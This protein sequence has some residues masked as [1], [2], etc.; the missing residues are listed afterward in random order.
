MRI[1]TCVIL[2]CLLLTPYIHGQ[3]TQLKDSTH[4][5]SDDT[6]QSSF[7]RKVVEAGLRD[8]KKSK[9]AYETS[10]LNIRQKQ[11]FT[12][13][14]DAA[15]NV[16]IYLGNGPN[17]S[18]IRAKMT[19]AKQ[20]FR[21]VQDGIF[22]NKGTA[23]TERNLSVS[24]AI[25]FQLINETEQRK[26]E[27]DLYADRLVGFRSQIDSLLTDSAIY[28]FPAD[29]VQLVKY[30]SR[31]RILVK[32]GNPA[33]NMLNEKLEE[34]QLLQ[35]DIEEQLFAFRLTYE[36]IDAYRNTLANINFKREFH[37]I[38]DTVGYTRPFNDILKFSMA[39]ERMALQFYARENLFRILILGAFI[40]LLHFIIRAI[41]RKSADDTSESKQLI[42]HYPLPASALIGLSIYQFAFIRA[43]FI[44]SF[45]IWTIQVICLLIVLNGFITRYWLRF[46]MITTIL[47]LLACMDNFILQASRTERWFIAA[48]SIA[49][50]IHGS[51]TLLNGHRAELKERYIIIFIRFLVVAQVLSLWLN[52]FGRYNLSKTI[53]TAGYTGIVTAILF[54]WVVRLINEGLELGSAIYRHP[55]RKLLY[56]NFNRIGTKAPTFLY[57]LLIIGW[58]VIV[59]RNFYFF[60]RITVPFDDFLHK[61]RT[62][63]DYTFSI[64]GIFLFLVIMFCSLL[65]SRLISYFAADPQAIHGSKPDKKGTASMGSWILLIR[66]FIISVGLFLSFAASGL[67][68]DKITIVLGALGVGIGLGL[69]GLVSNL[70]SG[71]IIAF[72]RPVNVG[73]II[74]INGKSGTMKSIGF[75]SS[76]VTLAD[77]A[78]LIIPN[79]DLL[80]NHL[81]NWSMSKNKRRII[82]A[83]SVAYGSDLEQVKKILEETV[84]GDE[85]IL[86]YP[87]TKAVARRF[88]TSAIDFE[89]IF[90]IKRAEESM[91]LT[92]D[93][94]AAINSSFKTEGIII[95]LPQQ[96]IRIMGN[97]ETGH[98]KSE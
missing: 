26:K 2:F 54:I 13:L 19:T 23:Q 72:E 70:V 8:R 32:Q 87:E 36:K 6:I 55:E 12:S 61:E 56:I 62:L 16:K 14:T 40:F 78:S 53:M 68:L 25:L 91:N 3:E 96:E 58:F 92:S 37:N 50:I 9:A 79:G 11:V 47:F 94:I 60:K 59:G 52:L 15:R 22:T 66:I 49:G 69:Q 93:V 81:I 24:A 21:V 57:V 90:W 29:S 41:Q 73:D 71:L 86:P 48:L 76:I 75:R 97:D 42:I 45:C 80:N 84:S 5:V 83:V 38:W 30:L 95:P 88:N 67:P 77:G 17:V 34:V 43:P 39:K 35:N 64:N 46:W 20:S 4:N 18:A 65:L 82:I 98:T 28:A 1:L 44:F 10:R 89:L 31:L 85:R 7:V 27:I 74:E 33:D 63:G 51:V